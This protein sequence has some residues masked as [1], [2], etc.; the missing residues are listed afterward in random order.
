MSKCNP[1]VWAALAGGGDGHAPP[2]G[3]Y[4]V[5]N[6]DKLNCPVSVQG[7]M[8]NISYAHVGMC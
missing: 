7:E 3:G 8:G 1:V 4:R 2:E 5:A 6:M